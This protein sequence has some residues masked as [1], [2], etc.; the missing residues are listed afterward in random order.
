MARRRDCQQDGP[1]Q[2]WAEKG[3]R[4]SG[5]WSRLRSGGRGLLLLGTKRTEPPRT[6]VGCVQRWRPEAAGEGVG[7]YRETPIR[8][9]P[10]SSTDWRD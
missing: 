8:D 9:H 10:T 7:S 5:H 6:V 4:W 2:T 1:F 3:S